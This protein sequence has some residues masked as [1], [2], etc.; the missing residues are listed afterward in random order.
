MRVPVTG[1]V[2]RAGGPR[3]AAQRMCGVC[4]LY[5][6]GPRE[7]GQQS[8]HR[9]AVGTGQGRPSPSRGRV[10]HLVVFKH[11]LLSETMIPPQGSY[12][13]PQ[14][15]SLMMVRE[16]CEDEDV[17]HSSTYK[18]NKENIKHKPSSSKSNVLGEDV[19]AEPCLSLVHVSAS[20]TDVG[21]GVR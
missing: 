13:N 11:G 8:S 3:Q 4:R 21:A 17:R 2:D 16:V 15:D 6:R 19:P 5:P 14:R 12:L 10:D 18:K 20:Q 7:R 1:H 9:R